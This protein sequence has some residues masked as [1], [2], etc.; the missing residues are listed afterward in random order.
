[1]RIW[2]MLLLLAGLAG[3]LS[4]GA[5]QAPKAVDDVQK[6]VG[7]LSAA[8]MAKMKKGVPGKPALYYINPKA[9]WKQYHKLMLDPVT[10]WR[11]P[12]GPSSTISQADRQMLANYFYADIRK[13]MSQQVDMST[14]P[15]PGV[16]RVRVAIVN[17]EP[18]VVALDVISSVVPQAVAL[19]T[20][21]DAM[22][23]K[24]AF[25]G[26][27]TVA[28]E[29]CDSQSG[30]LLAAWVAGRVGGKQLDQAQFDSWGDVEQA[31]DFWAQNAA[32]HFCKLQKK[33][34][35]QKPTAK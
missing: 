19:S 20:L 6:P 23:G 14:M 1:M 4:L 24:P 2:R 10:F 7:F 12:G 13:A 30:E 16:M 3:L 21:K 5:C 8:T 34:G 25:V 32:Y 31:M 27:A 28:A 29:V 15:G 26:Q 18:S 11:K 35:C 22:T 17:A 33:K 9:Q